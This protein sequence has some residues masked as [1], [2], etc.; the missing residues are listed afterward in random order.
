MKRRV[1]RGIRALLGSS[2]AWRAGSRACSDPLS[3]AERA[4]E[5]PWVCSPDSDRLDPTVLNNLPFRSGEIPRAR[6]AVTPCR[7]P[8]ARD[9]KAT[10][11]N[12][13]VAGSAC[14]ARP[15]EAGRRRM[16][17]AERFASSNGSGTGPCAGARVLAPTGKQSS[18]WR[19][20]PGIGRLQGPEAADCR[21]APHR[22]RTTATSG[23]FATPAD[24]LFEFRLGNTGPDADE[25]ALVTFITTLIGEAG[26][27]G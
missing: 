4:R 18:A 16:A 19:R 5:P 17:S 21:P 6:I 12:A 1:V 9:G 7:N 14:R 24:L 23:R 15:N 26:G 22:V 8:S 2:C 13:R 3:M 25:D 20:R 10:S 11:P 27:T